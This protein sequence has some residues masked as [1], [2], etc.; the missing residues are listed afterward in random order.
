MP[1][2]YVLEWLEICVF[3]CNMH[4]NQRSFLV[5]KFV[6][7][8]SLSLASL[9]CSCERCTSGSWHDSDVAIFSDALTVQP[10]KSRNLSRSISRQERLRCRMSLGLLSDNVPWPY[11]QSIQHSALLPKGK[12][13]RDI[14]WYDLEAVA[15][16]SDWSI[17]SLHD[18]TRLV[19]RNFIRVPPSR[20]N[21]LRF[22]SGTCRWVLSPSGLQSSEWID[23]AFSIIRI[24]VVV[25]IDW[26]PAASLLLLWILQVINICHV[27]ASGVFYCLTSFLFTLGHILTH[28]LW[29][30]MIRYSI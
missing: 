20:L 12:H 4:V 15:G 21:T 14:R 11:I 16:P 19:P 9:G 28:W 7:D 18:Y 30:L 8:V 26:L 25:I 13:W 2:R 10:W 24:F 29:W 17:S 23:F 1:Y 3:K 22:I 5:E 6:L 27:S